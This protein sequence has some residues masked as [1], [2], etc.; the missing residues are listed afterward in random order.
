MIKDF[1]EFTIKTP[2]P[3]FSG[4]KIKIDQAK[5][6]VIVVYDFKIEPS[7]FPEK[8]KVN[9]MILQ[10]GIGEILYVIFTTAA[11]LMDQIK[12]IP[13]PD[14]FPFRTKIMKVGERLEFT[15]AKQQP[16]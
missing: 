4:T 9:Y 2:P 13:K 6:K 15:S 8:G 5:D 1:T 14:G 12:Q 7:K 11:A 3:A 10:I 16:T